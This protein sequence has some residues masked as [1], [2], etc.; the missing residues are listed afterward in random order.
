M[1]KKVQVIIFIIISLLFI[2]VIGIFLTDKKNIKKII[3][4][5]PEKEDDVIVAQKITTK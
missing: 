4:I 5:N 2:T 1:L 3:S